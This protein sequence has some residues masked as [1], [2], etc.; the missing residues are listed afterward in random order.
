MKPREFCLVS[1]ID[2][3]GKLITDGDIFDIQKEAI[4]S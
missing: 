2:G 1:V 3:E 4:L